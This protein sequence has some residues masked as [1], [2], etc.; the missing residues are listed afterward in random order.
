MH[1]FNNGD[2][3][4]VFNGGKLE[5]WATVKRLLNHDD[6]YYAVLFDG[7]EP[8]ALYK[9]WVMPQWQEEGFDPLTAGDFSLSHYG[10]PRA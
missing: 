9:R 1:N 8:G 5:G 10:T 3:V 7:D 6:N 2:R 4:K